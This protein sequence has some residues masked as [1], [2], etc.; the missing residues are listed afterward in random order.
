ML[1]NR[2][3]LDALFQTYLNR[4]TEAQKAAGGRAYPNQLVLE[5]IALAMSVT[6]SG[7]VHSWLE[8]IKA[9]SEWIGDRNIRNIKIGQLTVT[10]RDF[11]NTIAVRRNDIEDDQYGMFAPLIGMMGSDAEEIWRRLAVESLLGNGVWAD[12]IAFFCSGRKLGESTITNAVTTALSKT[13]VE[14]ALAAIRAW[15]L[16][17]GEPADSVPDCLVVGPSLEGTAK[18]IVEADIEA[19]SGGT[20]AVSNVSPARMLKVRVDSR[21][22]G[23]YAAQWYVTARKGGIPAVCVQKRKLPVLTRLDRDTD[24]NVFM[25]NEYLYGTDARGEAFLTLPFLAYAGGLQSV[26]A[27]SAV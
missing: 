10:N 18:S 20:L 13:A 27:W 22:S 5:D 15:K 17:G 24:E 3:N 4:F 8:Q 23:D 19:N 6:G 2:A 26:T 7:T 9:M 12:G 1:I 14:T 11:E 25:R 21:I 16:F